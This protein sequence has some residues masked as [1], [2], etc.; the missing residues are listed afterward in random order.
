MP[1]G[2]SIYG[3]S[4]Y[5]QLE[6]PLGDKVGALLRYVEPE[7]A[8]ALTKIDHPTPFT[9]VATEHEAPFS[10]H[11]YGQHTIKLSVQRSEPV[12][13][14]MALVRYAPDVQLQV[15]RSTPETFDQI[16]LVRNWSDLTKP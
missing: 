6:L 14:T 13:A 9:M 11:R 3:V 1:Y 15:V 7:V 10:V 16:L 8:F 5:G 2:S 12:P 4:L